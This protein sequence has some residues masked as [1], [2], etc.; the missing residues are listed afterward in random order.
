[1]TN[2]E[3]NA[4]DAEAFLSE[5]TEQQE[6][7]IRN[8]IDTHKRNESIRIISK[9]FG[10]SQNAVR[11][12]LSRMRESGKIRNKLTNK[13]SDSEIN[14]IKK[15]VE[16]G[17]PPVV[18]AASLKRLPESIRK[19]IKEIYGCIPVIDIEGERWERIKGAWD[20]EISNLGRL[21]KGQ[22]R[23]LNGSISRDGYIQVNIK[24]KLT[25]IHRLV[26][27]AFVPNPDGKELVDY[28]DGNRSNNRADN[29]RWVTPKENSNNI[30]RKKLL[31]EQAEKR[32]VGKEINEHLKCIFDKGISK[33][34]LIRRIIDYKVD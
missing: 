21:R 27:E 28:I 1:M 32:L 6:E 23:L 17:H 2:K 10:I 19:K 5:I 9:E 14:T 18:I 13:W 34:D 29:L 24:G 11:I 26:A 16:E 30:H 20:Y 25:T 3:K 33:L 7:S 4:K 12:V 31:K 22:R 15:M 8:A